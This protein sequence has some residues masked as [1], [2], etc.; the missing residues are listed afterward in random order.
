MKALRQ[1]LYF[2]RARAGL[3]DS[4]VRQILSISQRNN[5]QRD[6][7]GC[8]LFS[9]LHF[10]QALE[11]DPLV[12]DELLA[13]IHAD[14]RHS[15]LVVAIDHVVAIRKFP[16]WSMGILYKVEVA[17]LL[18]ALLSGEKISETEA[19]EMLAAMKPDTVMGAL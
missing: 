7:T 18:E 10:A 17:G 15:D 14:E 5:R 13:R 12:L 6:L 1:I 3:A 16:Q 2:S 4:D 9:G 11:G 19:I 8:L